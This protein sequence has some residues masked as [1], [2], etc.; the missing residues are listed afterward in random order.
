M[1]NND[2]FERLYNELEDLL[3][4][5]YHLDPTGSS[6]YFHENRV[7][8]LVAKNLRSLRELR[9]FV[10]HDKRTDTIQ[11]CLV[12][13]EAIR[14][15]EKTLDS[16]QRPKRAIDVCVTKD[17]ILFAWLT[18]PVQPL[19]QAM[20][21][22]NISHVPVLREDGTMFGVFSGT[23]MFAKGASAAP[24]LIGPKTTMKDF[25]LH[26]PIS[27]HAEKYVF[28]NRD[29]PIEDLIMYFG[30]T[31]KDGKKTKMLFVTEHGKPEERILGLITPWNILDDDVVAA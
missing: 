28:V 20:L 10:V 31:P 23:T 15:L 21:Q 25:E 3:R 5:K 14:F 27:A 4:I 6:V 26:L 13:D 12:T 19:L 1:D 18:S 11:A 30:E 24:F 16:L 29:T 2:K 9:N 8:G 22:R 7:G 17:K